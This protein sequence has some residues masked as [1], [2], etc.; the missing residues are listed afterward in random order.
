VDPE[1]QKMA[2]H[3]KAGA[4][5]STEEKKSA[6][7]VRLAAGSASLPDS[8]Q[9]SIDPLPY[10]AVIFA[11]DG[12]ILKV[13]AATV[14]L[15]EADNANQLLGKNIYATGEPGQDRAEEAAANLQSGHQIQLDK[16]HLTT[17]KGKRRLLDIV[18]VPVIAERGEVEYVLGFASD[19]S[20]QMRAEHEQALLAA[21]VQSSDDA[22][23]SLS[24]SAPRFA[25]M[26]WNKGAERLFGFTADEAIGRSVAELYVV[27]ELREHA[28]TLLQEDIAG[29]EQ[30]PELVNHLEVQAQRKDGTRIEVSI[31]VSGIFEDSGKLL[32]TSCIIRDI[33]ERKRAEREQ[34][35]LAA[36]VNASHDAIIGYSKDLKITNWNP[37]AE[38]LYGF[39]AKEAIGRGFDL[40]VPPEELA[41]SLEVSR[42][43]VETGEP[44]SFEQRAK[45]AGGGWFV[46][47]INIF[48]IRDPAGNIIAGAGIGRDITR[49]KQI[50]AELREAHEYTRGLI[51]SS[52][53]A[54][55]M[56]DGEMRIT[57]GN[58]QLARLIELPKK[59][60]FGTL[61]ESYFTDPAAARAAIRKTFA[62]GFVSN[63]ELAVKAASGK[64]IPVSFNASLFYKAGKVFGIFGVARDVTEQRAIERTLREERE[65]SRSLVQSSPD[66]LLV[67]DASLVLTD[68]NERALE[69]T[70]YARE[71]LT[72]SKLP[73]L[74]TDPARARAAVEKARDESP[75]HD[76]ELFLLTKTA[77]EIPV[78]LNASAFQD[79][80]LSGH[81]I[82]VAVRDV[83]ESRRAQEAN[84]LLA[85]IVGSSG[86]AIY[87]ETTNM[88]LTSW[89]PAAEALFGY[90]AAEV[91]GRS[92][93]LLVPLNQ[94]NELAEHLRRIGQSRKA[95]HYET[96]R[97]RKDG[98]TVDVAVTQSP[99][100]DASGAVAALA[101]T[102][103]DISERKRM[104][105]ELTKARDAALEGARLKSE[106]LANMSHEIRTPL[107]SI[108]GMTGL[109][110][111][112]NLIAEQREFAHDVR[113]SG[114]VLLALVNNILDFSK[115]T[116][117]KLT[118][119]EFDFELTSEIEGAVE[120]VADQARRKGLELT[121]SVEPDVPR[122]LHGDA[123]RLRQVLL[124][125]MSNAV[126][127][128][129]HGEVAVAVSKL[130][131][132]PKEAILRFEVRDTG[133]GIPTDKLDLLFQPFTQV[134]AS[135]SRHYGGTGLG[136]SIA[137]ELV[138]RMQGT[139]SVTSTPGSGS[140]FWFTVK[141]AKQVDVSKPASERFASLAGAK[142][143]VV[144]DNAN[145]RRI[146]DRQ[147]SS[148]GMRSTIAASA[149][150]ALGMMR[151]AAKTEPYRVA[152]V[153][154]MMPEID[155]I[156]LARRIKS[157]PALAKTAI[158]FV[159]S[160]GPSKEFKALL[161][162]LEI[163]GWLMK[164]VP[165][166]SLY[167][168]LIR[169]LEPAAESAPAAGAPQEH[170]AQPAP[171]P[172]KLKLPAGLKLRVLLAE[173]NPINQKV[174]VLQLRK[175]GLEVDAVANGHEAVEAV[176]R[177]PY[178][179]IFM[180]CQ[181]PEM[182]G[183]EAT[184]EIRRREQGSGRHTAI[185]AM[186]AHALPGD[187]EKCLAA[188]M[189]GYISKPVKLEALER[190]LIETLAAK[191]PAP[192]ATGPAAALVPT[193]IGGGGE[194]HPLGARTEAHSDEK[195]GR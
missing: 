48:P 75:V 183:Y 107:N 175:L 57:D 86:D 53:D 181:M 39:S 14:Q 51:E 84:S 141:L 103:R 80:D 34:R 79:R 138:E 101:V 73:S 47:H 167:D 117:G 82:V 178:D 105:A 176:S 133:I 21:I 123:G 50:E 40:F 143:I 148:W 64:E 136:L 126:K 83:S 18:A 54:M 170:A 186:T 77:R 7:V 150:E 160:V 93:A 94:R 164:P 140:T 137:R 69:L 153:D 65:Y 52:I 35:M 173:D 135:T 154:V 74:F 152:L 36:I 67:S 24:P 132:N 20:G 33:S 55:V 155:G 169:V 106:F 88:V 60:L 19:I 109:L 22:I 112:T 46:S 147:V 151:G 25:V 163:G 85:S 185:V 6:A 62:D 58:Q 156:E 116:A 129:E 121:V 193:G 66:A 78:S 125:L 187:R 119:E 11:T 162:G 97:L 1:T 110:L 91:V 4:A 42:R 134:D 165:E 38:A 131:E 122:F 114:D 98:S 171:R 157:D 92:A 13:N 9:F 70:G 68:V 191:P 108:I 139:I 27:P 3:S 59:A 182:D 23:F 56:I 95:E 17:F 184:Q 81:R 174:A 142:V 115:I 8:F 43:V 71:E 146:L 104:E 145:S 118:L 111:D 41:R 168:A 188:G 144:D 89:N 100:L 194:G 127:F 166:S 45:N 124:N 87:S 195:A 28:M 99:I 180:D 120:I 26:T 159:S 2:N 61:F 130:S 63:V 128:T 158:I 72:G 161:Q 10:P 172:G 90:H 179:V 149:E 192:D 76:I 16:W 30:H 32:G 190:E 31:V 29:F 96:V 15:F 37:A 189:D 102:V 12:T 177:L 5:M 113:E 49:L 44:V